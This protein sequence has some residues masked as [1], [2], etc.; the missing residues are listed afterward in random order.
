MGYHG[1]PGRLSQETLHGLRLVCYVTHT[2]AAASISN[3]QRAP[4]YRKKPS[5]SIRKPRSML[6]PD[7]CKWENSPNPPP[8]LSPP[9]QDAY[10]HIRDLQGNSL[11]P[12]GPVADRKLLKSP[13]AL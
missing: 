3:Q 12:V 2:R 6:W 10:A 7:H 1:I 9:S 13:N 11:S 5:P 8:L 4:L